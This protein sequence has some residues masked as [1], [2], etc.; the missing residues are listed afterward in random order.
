MTNLAMGT[1]S[2]IISGAIGAKLSDVEEFGSKLS[3][4]R[5]DD[6]GLDAFDYYMV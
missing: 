2:A 5:I 6:D 4:N 3:F 1:L